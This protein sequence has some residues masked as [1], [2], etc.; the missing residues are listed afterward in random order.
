MF[1]LNLLQ[2]QKESLAQ[3][4]AVTDLKRLIGMCHLG[5]SAYS[6]SRH[7]C[8][9]RKRYWQLWGWNPQS[10]P[11]YTCQQ[12][13]KT[14]SILWVKCF[15]QDTRQRETLVGLKPGSLYP[16]TG[17][18]VTQKLRLQIVQNFW[19][20]FTGL[21]VTNC[22]MANFQS[23]HLFCKAEKGSSTDWKEISLTVW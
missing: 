4:K 11:G 14:I 9:W 1:L 18:M 16:E 3:G 20:N 6:T 7:K 13:A 8:Y 12:F 17:Q 23:F 10:V 21:A 22:S 2:R 5:K 19:W 15:F